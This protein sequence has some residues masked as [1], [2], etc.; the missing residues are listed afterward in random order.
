[1]ESIHDCNNAETSQ[2]K[3]LNSFPKNVPQELPDDPVELYETTV[4][5]ELDKVRSEGR[6][7]NYKESF[8]AIEVDTEK[9]LRD[10]EG[11]IRLYAGYV[12]HPGDSGFD[13]GDLISIP[14]SDDNRRAPFRRTHKMADGSC[15]QSRKEYLHL[16][17]NLKKYSD[18]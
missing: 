7:P 4:K 8:L 12:V 16:L 17:P 6:T 14:E 9:C 1:M 2:D 3:D 18:P 15:L 13:I 5:I 11:S 10:S